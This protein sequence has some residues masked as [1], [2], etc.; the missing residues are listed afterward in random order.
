[1]PQKTSFC[2]RALLRSDLKRYWPLLFLYVAVWVVILPMQM[3]RKTNDCLDMASSGLTLLEVTQHNLVVNTMTAS[4][5]M[6]L[7]FGCFMAMAVWSYLMNGRTVGLL[8]TLPVTRT[9]AFFSHTLAALAMLTAGN[10]IIFVLTA[11]CASGGGIFCWAEL[12]AWLLLTELMLVFFFAL[13]SLCAMV[14]GWLLAIPVLYGTLNAAAMLCF[15]VASE[16]ADM[17][18][19]G[20]VRGSTP[21]L[22]R[23]LTPVRRLWDALINGDSQLITV[24]VGAD[25]TT[26]SRFE[27]PTEAFA[28]CAVYAAVGVAL[29][30]LVWWLYKKR[31]SECAG[32]AIAF[33][34][35]RP[36]ARWCIGLCGG[37]GLGLFLSYMTVNENSFASL[38]I[39]Q[40]VAAV[41]CFFAAQMLLKKSFRI[42]SARWWLET[43]ALVLAVLAVTLCV[44]LDLTGYRTRVPDAD[45]VT[46]VLVHG[47]YTDY[48]A[49]DPEA[50]ELITALHTAVVQQYEETGCT[51]SSTQEADGVQGWRYIHLTYTL[52]NGTK[53]SR[54]YDAPLLRDS[55]VYRLLTQL[56]NRTDYRESLIGLDTLESQGGVDAVMGGYL[57]DYSDG[58]Y[59]ELTRAQAQELVRCAMADAADG[60]IAIDPLGDGL[61]DNDS[62]QDL[63][64]EVTVRLSNG[65][66]SSV[67]LNRPSFA[68]TMNAFVDSID[69]SSPVDGGT[70]TEQYYDEFDT[71]AT[72]TV[73]DLLSN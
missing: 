11:L 50:V 23:W 31:P 4:V 30:A 43:L 70:D 65:D 7:L 26:I 3:L 51:L 72:H 10:V 45:G 59:T 52:K 40:T 58:S 13:A 22:V 20:Y 67:Y 39:W 44:K 28:V 14:T 1:M 64:I 15:A 42:F 21:L 36:A 38:A 62:K 6:S 18:Y 53:L 71:N 49:G 57:N 46:S 25:T 47:P 55:E 37:W 9:Q 73:S 56:M 60:S 69:L 16:V 5:V 33:R 61:Y 68:V 17:F 34:V 12:G 8:H 29:L 66:T 24:Q 54:S 2:N 41:I 35:L 63:V 19:F 48:T 27:L 32:D